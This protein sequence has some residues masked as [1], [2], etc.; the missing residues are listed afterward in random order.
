MLYAKKKKN[1]LALHDACLP[2]IFSTSLAEITHYIG[3]S[4]CARSA[5]SSNP[6]TLP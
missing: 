3:H 2:Y 4:K 6:E 5:I 1:L